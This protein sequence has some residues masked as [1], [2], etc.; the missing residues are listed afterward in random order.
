MTISL[1]KRIKIWNH[2]PSQQ[3]A[4]PGH[5]LRL[6]LT[7]AEIRVR[8]ITPGDIPLQKRYIKD[9]EELCTEI[10][11]KLFDAV[12]CSFFF[13]PSVRLPHG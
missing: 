5:Y 11:G 9:A 3:A 12:A 7:L 1:A 13:E 8:A 4:P 6:E 10:K 2:Q